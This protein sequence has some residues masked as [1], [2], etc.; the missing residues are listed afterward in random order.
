VREFVC[1]AL[2]IVGDNERVAPHTCAIGQNW[3][4]SFGR[5]NLGENKNHEKLCANYNAAFGRKEQ[6]GE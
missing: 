3:I 1:G 4:G 5:R 2:I 6:I